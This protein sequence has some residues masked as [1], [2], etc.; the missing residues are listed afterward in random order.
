MGTRSSPGLL[1]GGLP[2]VEVKKPQPTQ[3][4]F[5]ERLCDAKV[6]SSGT[7]SLGIGGKFWKVTSP[8]PAGVDNEFSPGELVTP[9][10][11]KRKRST[12]S[13]STDSICLT[14]SGPRGAPAQDC[15]KVDAADDVEFLK[16]K[17]ARLENENKE[18]KDKLE[19]SELDQ[20]QLVELLL[21]AQKPYL[22]GF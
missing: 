5:E 16:K 18:L 6:V 1:E 22:A 20:A 4:A 17:V 21:D 14:S 13:S 8:F 3:E 9:Q 12:G 2:N 11:K 19:K 7:T 10:R 15:T